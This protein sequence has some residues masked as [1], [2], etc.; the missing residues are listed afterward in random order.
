M[1][2]RNTAFGLLILAVVLAVIGIG[3]DQNNQPQAKLVPLSEFPWKN[4]P[5]F[6]LPNSGFSMTLEL[7]VSTVEQWD[8][9][10]QKILLVEKQRSP[11]GNYVPGDGAYL[12]V[13][14]DGFGAEPLYTF[15][16]FDE[17]ISLMEVLG[18]TN[19]PAPFIW[20]LQY[21]EETGDYRLRATR[22]D[23]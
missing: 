19:Y 16:P 2:T 23:Q 15:I 11:D 17:C 22:C 6:I 8:Q 3:V 20:H 21:E 14:K 5:A 1:K 18:L 7:G 9:G 4:Y 10:Y 13:K 12:F